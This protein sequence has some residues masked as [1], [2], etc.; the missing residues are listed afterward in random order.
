M[1]D[2]EPQLRDLMESRARDAGVTPIPPPAVLRRARR[3]QVGT[4]LGGAIV[5]AVLVAG[6]ITG[7]RALLR[8]DRTTPA[9]GATT[10]ATVNGITISYPQGWFVVD[11]DQAQLNGPQPGSDLPRL[12]LAVSPFDPGDRLGC[13]GIAPAPAPTFIMT[14]QEQPLALTGAEASPWPVSLEAMNLDTS[15]GGCYPGWE[16]LRAGWTS[17]RRTFEARVGLAPELTDAERAVLLDAFASMTFEAATGEPSSV[18]LA[19][20][21]VSGERWSLTLTQGPSGPGLGFGWDQ[22]GGGG[23]GISAP[24]ESGFGGGIGGSSSLTY[25]SGD[26]TQP[27]LPMDRSGVV[28]AAAARVEYQLLDGTT[29]E[30]TLSPLPDGTFDV[31]AVAFLVFVPADT[32]LDA[33]YLVAYDAGGAEV[34]KE[35]MDFSPV[36]L[37]P[38]IIDEATPAQL[39]V[40]H[41]LQVAGGVA[42][43]YFNEHDGSFVGLNTETATA[44]SGTVTYNTASVAV[45]NEVSIRVTGATTI[46]LASSTTDGQ[47]YSACFQDGAEASTYGRNDTSDPSSCSN[48]GWP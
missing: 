17:G 7:G 23:G 19:T 8:G 34:G 41:A 24:R 38:Q 4:V 12:V 33:G 10:T 3:R 27:P 11:P 44:I 2:L 31:S 21:E 1:T 20:G 47:V 15:G 18:R 28:T 5:I 45:P 26:K 9:D 16:F 13:P 48:V 6:S 32:L 43:R 35:Y 30:A 29:L 40:L 36:W 37:T 14:I 42:R 25:P 22:Q 39:E 46:V